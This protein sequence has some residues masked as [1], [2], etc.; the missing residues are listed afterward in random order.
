MTDSIL[1]L[2]IDLVARVLRRLRVRF[3]G[4]GFSVELRDEAKRSIDERIGL[5]DAARA[6]LVDGVRAIDELRAEAE[7]QRRQAQEA[8]A[9]VSALQQDKAALEKQ[10]QALKTVI[11]SDVE[12][13]REVAGI[14]SRS[15]I[16]RERVV[17]FISGVLASV[18]A[19][20]MV[21]GIVKLLELLG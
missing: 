4:F 7:R 10:R 9:Q 1:S 13:F 18:V 2:Y 5:I 12:S 11:Q 16:R 8:L 3:D 6:N 21:W 15:A 19:S 20:G 17:G 14:P